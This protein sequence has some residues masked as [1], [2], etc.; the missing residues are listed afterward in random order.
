MRVLKRKKGL[1]LE[2]G[3][4]QW[5]LLVFDLLENKKKPFKMDKYIVRIK[6]Q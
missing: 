3:I 2:F 5:H 1:L 6:Y 4:D